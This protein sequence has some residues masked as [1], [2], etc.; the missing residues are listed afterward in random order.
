MAETYQRQSP[1]AHLQLAA[2]GTS[3]PEESGVVMRE[4]AHRAMV[5]LRGDASD[6]AFRS[7]VE[8]TVG[9]VPPTQA[10]SAVKKGQRTILW[11]G[12]DEWLVVAPAEER[13]SLPGKLTDA[14]AALHGA[15]VEVGESMT[16]IALAGTR[17]RDVLAKGC[18]IDL[19]PGAFGAESVVRTRLAKTG[20]I[21]HRT[22]D[23]PSPQAPTYEVYVHRSFADYA[24]RWLEDASL[25][26][27]VA[28]A[29]S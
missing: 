28:I 14:L 17:A 10:L 8:E 21:L 1:L 5:T 3:V 4:H 20:V 27:G 11:M 7:A 12:P 24:W 16:V 6:A 18:T 23:A 15:A 26:Y 9:V 19:H 22:S 2:A 29:G 13:E 25:E